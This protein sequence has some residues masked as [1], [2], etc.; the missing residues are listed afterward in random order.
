MN[1]PPGR[2]FEE[3]KI[4]YRRSTVLIY[5]MLNKAVDAGGF[6]DALLTHRGA[7][8]LAVKEPI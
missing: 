3:G 2:D 1:C 8:L 5:L 6:L 4:M 7:S